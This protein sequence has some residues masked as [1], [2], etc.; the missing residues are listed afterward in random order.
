MPKQIKDKTKKIFLERKP[1]QVEVGEWWFKGCFIQEQ[2]HP[3]LLK[4]SI[5]ADTKEQEHIDV[6]STF[7]EAKAICRK[8]EVKDNLKSYANL[9]YVLK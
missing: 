7:A 4:Y 3:D 5:F 9:I 2:N 1:I 6:C 8:N